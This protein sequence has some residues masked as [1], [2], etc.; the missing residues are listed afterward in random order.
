MKLRELVEFLNDYLKVREFEDDSLN[1][2][3]VEGPEEVQTIATA[4]DASLKAFQRAREW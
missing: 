3:Q 4:V 1:G 2:L